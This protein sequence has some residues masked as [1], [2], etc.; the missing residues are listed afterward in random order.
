M[1]NILAFLDG[2]MTTPQVFGWYHILCLIVISALCVFILRKCNN[3][4]EKTLD[5]IMIIVSVVLILF[6][7]YKQI[8]FSYNVESKT[9]GYAW[10]IFPFQFCSTPMYIILLAGLLNDCKFKDCLYGYLGTFSLFA[11]LAVVLVPSSVL[12]SVIGVN[13]Q[14]MVHHGAMVVIGVLLHVNNKVKYGHK[15]IL[16]PIYIFLALSGIA[17][18]L[19]SIIYSVLPGRGFNM[20]YISPHYDC[21]IP[22]LGFIKNYVPYIL[23]LFLYLAGFSAISYGILWAMWY[24]KEKVLARFEKYYKIG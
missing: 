14:T 12:V 13:I 10:Y 9:W 5:V 7:I 15:E 11:G 2:R 3:L 20:F 6:E 18:I 17:F 24:L 8:N 19:N 21:V 1:H 22:I 23:F 16:G 4:S